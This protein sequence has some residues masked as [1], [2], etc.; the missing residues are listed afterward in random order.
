[1]Q[2]VY[3]RLQ[4]MGIA[5]RPAAAPVAAYVPFVRSGKRLF[6]SGHLARRD[7][8]VHVGRLGASMDLAQGQAAA[9]AVGID[10]VG[11][12]HAA[13]GDLRH[14]VRIVK[15]TSVVQC[16][17]EFSEQHLVTNGCSELLGQVFQE[18]GRHART[19]FGVPQLPFGACLEIE[20]VAE[21]N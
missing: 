14:L 7:G 21:L 17:P 8:Q 5:L 3:Q 11:T 13:T 16:T 6:L 9:R 4:Q 20:L 12:L 15:L 1:M 18:A 2:D 19:A 10:L